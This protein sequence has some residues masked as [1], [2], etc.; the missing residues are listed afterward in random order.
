[1]IHGSAGLTGGV[2]GALVLKRK[3]G[4]A[5]AYLHV[6]GRDIENPAELALKWDADTVS[7]TVMGD[8]EEYRRSKTRRK[9]HKALEG[10]DEPLGAKDIAEL[11]DLPEN[12]VR[13]RLYQMSKDGEAK[14]VSRGL[15][16]L[17]NF[18]SKRNNEDANVTDVMD[19]M[20]SRT[21]DGA[22]PF[23]CIHG[24]PAGEVCYL[25]DPSHPAKKGT[26]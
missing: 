24:Y 7:W 12:T 25:C 14:V 22:S 26:L 20:D 17:H 19:V 16:E 3:R 5:D 10:A 6:D 8:A 13:Q 4:Q 15:Y 2:D 1:M 11:T 18:H 21:E 23:I 9:I